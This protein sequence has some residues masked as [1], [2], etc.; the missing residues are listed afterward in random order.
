[1]LSKHAKTTTEVSNLLENMLLELETSFIGN[2]DTHPDFVA[3][4]QTI[5]DYLSDTKH[6]IM[7]YRNLYDDD[8]ILFT[9][10]LATKRIQYYNCLL[11][12]A[13]QNRLQEESIG[14]SLLS[15]QAL[16]V[17]LEGAIFSLY[18]AFNQIHTLLNRLGAGVNLLS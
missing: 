3:A 15:L 9:I 8:P 16:Q 2:S 12:V 14:K 17:E 4:I 1:M 18:L 5:E 11:K 6:F 10:E 7:L 13:L